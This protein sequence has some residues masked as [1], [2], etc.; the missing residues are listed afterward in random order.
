MRWM[1]AEVLQAKGWNASRLAKAVA[2]SR[3]NILLQMKAPGLSFVNIELIGR[4]CL[5]LDCKPNDLL[6][7]AHDQPTY[8]KARKKARACARS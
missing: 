3:Q 7:F 2:C 5:L 4:I 6:K 8:H 1:L